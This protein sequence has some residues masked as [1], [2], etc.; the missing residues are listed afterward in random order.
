[1]QP[2]ITIGR[3]VQN[4]IV[5]EDP[6]VWRSHARIAVERDG[7]II[8]DASTNGTL[9]NGS[10][11]TGAAPVGEGDELQFGASRFFVERVVLST[12]SLS[13]NAPPQPAL[14]NR[15]HS[16]ARLFEGPVGVARAAALALVLVIAIPVLLT[17][18]SHPDSGVRTPAPLDGDRYPAISGSATQRKPRLGER[19][20]EDRTQCRRRSER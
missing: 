4:D 5:L 1:M 14:S 2:G 7:L 15:G 19:V 16:K 13:R 8:Y 20:F 12:G 18:A 10:R 11:I 6:A 17:G 9:V 3:D